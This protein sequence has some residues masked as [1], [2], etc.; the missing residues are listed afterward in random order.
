M[1]GQTGYA[2]GIAGIAGYG[3]MT[4]GMTLP[5]GSMLYFAE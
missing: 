5:D 1:D 4:N 3:T 2:D